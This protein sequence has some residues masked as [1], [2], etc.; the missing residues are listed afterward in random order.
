MIALFGPS[1]IE[2]L[3]LLLYGQIQYAAFDYPL[4]VFGLC[5]QLKKETQQ[6]TVLKV[7]YKRTN[8]KWFVK[9]LQELCYDRVKM[10]N[11]QRIISERLI[12]A[13]QELDLSQK[14]VA[15]ML[16]LTY[17]GYGDFERKRAPSIDYLMELS[18]IYKKPFHYFLGI[19][20]PA[21]LSEDEAELLNVYRGV[22][23]G[24]VKD[25][26]IKMLRSTI[27]ENRDPE[28]GTGKYRGQEQEREHKPIEPPP[29]PPRKLTEE[30]IGEQLLALFRML[31]S[32]Q[33]DELWKGMTD[34]ITRSELGHELAR[35]WQEREARKG[36]G[37][38]TSQLGDSTYQEEGG[39]GY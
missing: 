10:K 1:Q 37:S 27:D 38:Q 33:K 12:R 39:Q 14:D 7:T 11:Y 24:P 36:Q 16:G 35:L 13:R 19:D 34:Y 9:L 25:Y 2:F 18:R 22:E 29:E 30:E 4:H 8:V 5:I 31:S 26:I 20:D 32:E 17:Q 3:Q 21:F 23:P 6:Y 28:R 15:E